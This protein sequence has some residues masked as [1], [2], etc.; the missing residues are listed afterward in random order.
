M[1][2][3][4]PKEIKNNEFRVGLTP[5]AVGAYVQAGNTVYVEKG[6]GLGSGFEDAEFVANGAKIL[7]TAKEVWDAS[8]MIVKVKEP[9]ESEY[10]YFRP[11]LLIFTYFHLAADA[12]LT[13]ALLEK[14]V[15]AMAYET[16]QDK[17]KS[18]PCLYC[19]SEIAGRTA[20]IEGA[21]YLEKTYGGRGVMLGAVP[22]CEKAEVVILGGGNAGTNAARMAA[23]LGAKV[24]ILDINHYR[25]AYLDDVFGSQITTLYSSRD[26]LLKSLAKAD[27]VIGCVLLA[28]GRE[29]PKL[30]K[31][32]DL[33]IMKKGAV[34]VDIV[35]DQGGCFETTHPTT[36]ADPVYEVDGV[37]HY[38]VANIPGAVPR[39][40]TEALVNST[41][42]YGITLTKKGLAAACKDDPGLML[43]LNTY[44]GKCT[45]AAVA[46]ALDLEYV[47]PATLL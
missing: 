45:F 36:H 15:T 2:V 17:Q 24:T 29:A 19:M 3:G 37:M 46:E 20:I 11:G 35:V 47:D 32:E 6:A 22:G 14:K 23:G 26:N 8:E 12:E 27:L 5:G 7:D 34:I 25:L 40:S 16:I 43:G 1:I 39:T 10:Q 13:K 44:D 18:L 33:K 42:S 41:L 30:V 28:P 21:K 31:R 9:L 4:L 38:C